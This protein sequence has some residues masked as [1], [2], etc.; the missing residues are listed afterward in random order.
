MYFSASQCA[1]YSQAITDDC[2]P[3]ES[4]VWNAIYEKLQ[5]G[6]TLV[7]GE[8]GQPE[9]VMPELPPSM[10]SPSVPQ[11]VTRFQ[12]RAALYQAGLLDEVEAMIVAPSTDRMLQLAWQDALTFKRDSAFVAG[13]AASLGLS[14][15]QLDALFIAAAEIQ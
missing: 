2:T 3:V 12:A 15:P 7:V 4:S 14:D 1:F 11:E 9:V 10:E 5:Q 8:S 6:G 13:M